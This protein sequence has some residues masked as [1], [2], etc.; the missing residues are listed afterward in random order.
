MPRITFNWSPDYNSEKDA[1]VDVSMMEAAVDY[2]I[3]IPEGAS[4]TF[5]DIYTHVDKWLHSCGLPLDPDSD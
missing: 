4:I 1:D 5:D 3:D 2:S